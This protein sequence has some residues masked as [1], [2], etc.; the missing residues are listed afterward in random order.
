MFQTCVVKQKNWQDMT[1][2]IEAEMNER[3]WSYVSDH[4]IHGKQGVSA[5]KVTETNSQLACGAAACPCWND[6]GVLWVLLVPTRGD[7]V[8]IRLHARI[9]CVRWHSRRFVNIHVVLA[10][11]VVRG[12]QVLGLNNYQTLKGRSK[13][14]I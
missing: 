11:V 12:T 6:F 1:P 8:W 4:V 3:V 13:G 14:Q 10:A 5:V 9:W 7:A 2:L